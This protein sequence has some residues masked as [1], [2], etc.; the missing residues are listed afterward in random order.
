M[1]RSTKPQKCVCGEVG[2]SSLDPAL[3]PIYF[4][5]GAIY[6]LMGK[7]ARANDV[8]NIMSNFV[9]RQVSREQSRAEI[10]KMQISYV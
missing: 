8:A 1:C 10:Q 6:I 2:L 7:Q 3:V 4:A 5:P 9:L